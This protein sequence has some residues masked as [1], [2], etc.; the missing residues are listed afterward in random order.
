[1]TVRIKR[2]YEQAVRADGLRVLVDRIWPRG[3]SRYDVKLNQ[4]LKEV[5][6]STDL[7][8]WFGHK[9]E[10]WKEFQRRYRAELKTN[11][12]LEELH[13][14]SR[15]GLLTLLYAARDTEHNHALVLQSLLSQLPR[16]KRPPTSA[17]SKTR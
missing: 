16:R 1:M 7:R 2:V 12:A 14:L 15:Q 13:T 10:R 8:R 4:W 17:R 9:P 3:I 6:P 5:A 11:P